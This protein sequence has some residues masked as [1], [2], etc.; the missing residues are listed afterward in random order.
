M[1]RTTRTVTLDVSRENNFAYYAKQADALSRFLKIRF[2]EGGNDINLSPTDKVTL[3][4]E[5]ADGR[6]VVGLGSVASDGTA[7]VEFTSSMLAVVGEGECEVS[8]TG[9]NGFVL[10]TLSFVLYVEK[11]LC[12]DNAIE[13]SNEFPVFMQALAEMAKLERDINDAATD[14]LKGKM[15]YRDEVEVLPENAASGD[16]Y[17]AKKHIYRD[18]YCRVMLYGVTVESIDD[19]TDRLY[20]A[21][22][23]LL[24]RALRCAYEAFEDTGCALELVSG[25]KAYTLI[26][27]GIGDGYIDVQTQS[28]A[29]VYLDIFPDEYGFIKVP[30]QYAESDVAVY[31]ASILV[32]EGGMAVYDGE[33]WIPITAESLVD[34][35]AEVKVLEDALAEAGNSLGGGGFRKIGFTA[36]CDFVATEADGLTAFRGALNAATNGETI[37]VMP[38]V[39]KGVERFDVTKNIA[40][41][42]IGKP[43]INFPIW[44]S[45]GGVFSYESWSWETVYDSITSKWDGFRFTGEFTVGM[46]ANPDNQGYSG[47]AIL[48]DCDF[49]GYSVQICGSAKN[50]TFDVVAFTSGHYYGAGNCCTE[51][52]GCTIKA[53]GSFDASS[54]FDRF[55]RCDLYPISENTFIST[56]WGDTKTFFGCRMYAL[57]VSIA[58]SDSHGN[59]TD[60]ND[61]LVYAN[62]I[63]GTSGGYLVKPTEL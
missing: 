7:T 33:D 26:W 34:L 54:C 38:G 41:V 53:S 63:S 48:S 57:G 22:D 56:G 12:D 52:E 42:G 36:D 60:L 9:E 62:A 40:F 2:A 45:G 14:A 37:L 58:I 27:A 1:N 32:P 20:F 4:V 10:T 17:K 35:M 30:L 8:V 43:E 39:Y 19:N 50:C 24:F 59:G 28:D 46:E 51:F 13:S 55:V 5:R 18:G 21:E 16:V 15:T 29:T 11:K 47:K 23:T 3:T 25:G 61:T 6:K 31:T 49:V 44:I